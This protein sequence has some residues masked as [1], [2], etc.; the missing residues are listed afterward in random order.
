MLVSHRVDEQVRGATQ[1][2]TS[3]G[4]WPIYQCTDL[5]YGTVV[6]VRVPRFG[7]FKRLYCVAAGPGPYKVGLAADHIHGNRFKI[8]SAR[9]YVALA[10]T[11]IVQRVDGGRVGDV[12]QVRAL[13]GGGHHRVYPAV[14]P[15]DLHVVCFV[16]KSLGTATIVHG[17]PQLE[18]YLRLGKGLAGG[19]PRGGHRGGGG[20]RKPNQNAASHAAAP[21]PPAPRPPGLIPGWARGAL[22]DN[23][24]PAP[25]SLR[26]AVNGAPRIGFPDLCNDTRFGSMFKNIPISGSGSDSWPFLKRPP[27]R[28]GRQPCPA[29]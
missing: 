21:P 6:P 20:H 18:G 22:N 9:L 13:F 3:Q 1:V 2:V 5:F 29:P 15:K 7:Y 24:I 14:I 10:E 26:A 28:T 19:D 12:K 27:S 17:A 25:K 8:S 11:S 16:K 23:T 4:A